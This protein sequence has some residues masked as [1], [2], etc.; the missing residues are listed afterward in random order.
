MKKLFNRV[1]AVALLLGVVLLVAGVVIRRGRS[2]AAPETGGS[3][4][5]RRTA[6]V[7]LVF[8]Q[9][10]QSEL[11][12]QILETLITEFGKNNPG[13]T[14]ILDDQSYIALENN[15][16][17]SQSNAPAVGDI[18]AIDPLWFYELVKREQL[19]P[20]NIYREALDVEDSE[21]EYDAWAL[22]LVSFMTPLFYNID[23][24]RRA[25]FDR[26]PKTRS[27]FLACAKALSNDGRF[28]IA[29]A[30]DP[31]Y[32]QGLQDDIYS[33]LWAG[34]AAILNKD[35]KPN[36]TARP[37][38]ETLD[39]LKQFRSE[40]ILAP[41]CFSTTRTQKIDAFASGK[42]GFMVAPVQDIE[43]L[44][45]RMG[46]AGFG[47]TNIPTPDS[48]LERPSLGLSHW[49]AGI[50][51]HSGHKAEAWAFLSF[52][53]EH[54]PELAVA[55]HAAPGYGTDTRNHFR[56]DALYTKS[57]QIYESADVIDE[58]TGLPNVLTRQIIVREEMRNMLESNQ[59]AEA[60]AQRIQSRWEAAGQ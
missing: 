24:L 60:T 30:L 58:L 11:E 3:L 48:Y 42:I 25:G 51:R 19:E 16:L 53:A 31:E 56:N 4:S 46:D 17:T 41:N 44:R 50:S 1:I 52:L 34:G 20:L 39:F 9:W 49:Y 7:E 33:W 59:S 15:A 43:P 36:I 54:A 35:G 45:L 2:A 10:W 21:N 26:P 32:P 5:G 12:G 13:I 28:G 38:V 40:G 55:A 14:I 47:I 8:S 23:M 22:P 29:F 57:Y 37:V 18:V 6:K 27:D